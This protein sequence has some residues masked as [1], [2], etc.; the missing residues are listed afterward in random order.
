MGIRVFSLKDFAAF[1]GTDLFSG[2]SF[3][4]ASSA[5]VPTSFICFSSAG[6]A[7][8][9]TEKVQPLTVI[10]IV[11]SDPYG[12]SRFKLCSNILVNDLA[13]KTKGY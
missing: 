13:M 4:I 3:L 7:D 11:V 12:K 5:C 8:R 10:G 2:K 6:M 1:A 9:F